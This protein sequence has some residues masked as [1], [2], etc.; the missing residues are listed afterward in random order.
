MPDV[1]KLH[2]PNCIFIIDCPE[3]KTETPPNVEQRD[4]LYS[5]HK[6]AHILK[7]LVAVAPNGMVA[8]VSKLYG[9]CHG[10]SYVATDSGFLSLVKPGDVVLSDAPFPHM[11]R[12]VAERGAAVV[13]PPFFSG[14]RLSVE[15]AGKTYRVARV[16]MHVEMAVQR[17]KAFNILTNQVPISLIP[18]MSKVIHVCAA[19]ANLQAPIVT[20]K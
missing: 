7:F 13:M 1:I 5:H 16:R 14:D 4:F 15:D 3:I 12:R 17:L 10:D 9:G 6:G 20:P 2:Y 11:R 19:I 8:F 18:H